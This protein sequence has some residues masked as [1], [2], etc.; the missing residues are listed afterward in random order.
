VIF[1][2]SALL[3][4]L[5]SVWLLR[6]ILLPFV[7]GMVLAYLF[8]PL[9]GLLK[10]R[11]ISRTIGALLIITLVVLGFILLLLLIAPVLGSQLAAFVE[12]L[13]RNIARL[14]A[15]VSEQSLPWLRSLLG[16]SI[17]TGDAAIG[18]LLTQ[19][20]G[21]IAGFMKS[22]WSGGAA[23]ISIFSLVVVT[24]IVA[25]YLLVDWDRMIAKVDSWVPDR[26]RET[27][28]CLAREIDAGISGFVR[29]QST[30]CLLLGA[31]Y[32]ISLSMAG[33]NFGMLIGLVAGI[34]TFVPYVGSLTGLVL[35]VGV[36]VAQFWPDWGSILLIAGIFLF[37]QFIEGNFLQP[38][39]VGESVGLHPVWIIFALFASGYL[40]GFVGMLL[41]VPI[42]VAVGAL[43][44]F[45]MRRYL[46]SSLHEGPPTVVVAQ[47]APVTRLPGQ[48]I[49]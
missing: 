35:A 17:G 6:E 42:A 8:S 26:Q 28:R 47:E 27:V 37:G 44:R 43:A 23:L 9:A 22:L 11:G 46:D 4:L 2:A 20:A 40:F 33:L 7:M 21:W 31:F 48:R 13:P 14:Q 41:A 34:I 3:L 30:V 49:D 29:G 18:D 12:S 19:G 25:F 36:A 15:L 24:P 1:W 45:G 39:L 10:R 5:L 38:K 16:E 32:A